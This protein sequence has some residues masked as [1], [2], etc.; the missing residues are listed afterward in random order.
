MAAVTEHADTA[1][2]E[3]IKHDIYK[4]KILHN[5][6]LCTTA[7]PC[8]P[9]VILQISCFHVIYAECIC[10]EDGRGTTASFKYYINSGYNT[11]L[12]NRGECTGVFHGCQGREVFTSLLY[13]VI[14][15]VFLI[16]VVKDAVVI[17]VLVRL[18]HRWGS[19]WTIMLAI[20]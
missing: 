6:A 14:Q 1:G 17:Q 15:V 5:Y 16:L 10:V 11:G 12:T 20:L 18:F 9:L 8:S 4:R 13:R 3:D 7:L 19:R 2:P